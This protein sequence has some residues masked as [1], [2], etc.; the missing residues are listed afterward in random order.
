MLATVETFYRNA[1]QALLPPLFEVTPGPAVGPRADT[2]RLVELSAE[3]LALTPPEGADPTALREPA[4]FTQELRFRADGRTTDFLLPAD[5]RGEVVEVESPPGH[6]VRR[7]DAYAL[8][9]RVLRF[10]RAPE[11][12]EQAVWV[13]LRGERARGYTERCPCELRLVTSAWAKTSAEVDGLLSTVL[14]GVLNA[15]TRLGTLEGAGLPNLG[16]RLRLL[17]PVATLQELSRS[18]ERVANLDW[19]RARARFLVR[20]ELEQVVVVGQPEPV[21]LIRQVQKA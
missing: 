14:A 1:L 19:F 16:V 2:K 20:G 17:R 18:S 12:A 5:A 7:G 13:L 21:G 15:S 11:Q 4:W 10:Y 8:E 3:S 6:P 9:G